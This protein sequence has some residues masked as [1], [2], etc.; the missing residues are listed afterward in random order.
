MKIAV[1][2]AS[3]SWH[4]RD[5]QRAA[6]D[7]HQL[8][9]ISFESL[10]STVGPHGEATFFAGDVDLQE[11][12]GVLV[13]TMPKGSLQQVVLRMDILSSLA[14][15]GVCV[16]ND[17]KTIELSVD[18]YLTLARLAEQR[19]PVPRTLVCEGVDQALA[20]FKVL[21]GDVVIKPL[22][23]SMGRGIERLRS[24]KEA[25]ASFRRRAE[26]GD[27]IYVQQ[28]I[29]HGDWDVRFLVIGRQVL[30]MKRTRVGHWL[31]NIACG[32]KAAIHQPTNCEK[33]LALKVADVTGAE[34]VG[35]DVIYDSAT[36]K[37]LILEA[38]AAPGWTAISDILEMDV[39]EMILN[40]VA[41]PGRPDA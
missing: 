41:S 16:I 39:A 25:E 19:I 10:G 20:G 6:G 21:G 29:D 4:F 5:L 3:D 18:K 2:A 9:S 27:V 13:R 35:V 31:T 23:G 34:V 38:N 22:F 36:G 40:Q 17:P 14:R 33:Q 37:P 11:V 1:L 24:R 12:D 8:I 7:K 15:R 32:A 28:F 30:G 26:L